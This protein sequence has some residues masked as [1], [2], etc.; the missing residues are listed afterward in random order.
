MPGRGAGRRRT[1]ARV[2]SFR[3]PERAVAALAHAVP[4][5]HLAGPADRRDPDLPSADPPVDPA[6]ARRLRRR[7]RGTRPIP[8]RALT[9]AELVGTLLR[10]YGIAV[11][12]F[13]PVGVRRGGRGGCRRDLATRWR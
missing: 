5:R 12:D 7:V 1:R 3:T 9:D 10:C 2:P 11:V 13:R 8:E 6:A 4:V